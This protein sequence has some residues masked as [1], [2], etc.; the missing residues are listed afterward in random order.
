MKIGLLN[1]IEIKKRKNDLVIKDD[2]S[3]Y[4]K[5]GECIYFNNAKLNNEQVKK[6]VVDKI[7]LKD[8]K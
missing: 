1:P 5:L 8:K 3:V 7:M 4:N 2:G 6:F